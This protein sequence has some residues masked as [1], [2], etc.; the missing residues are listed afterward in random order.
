M[1]DV[2]N[3]PDIAVIGS[4]LMGHGIAQVFAQGGCK[5]RLQDIDEK[6]FQPA[7]SR[8]RANLITLSEHG[9]ENPERV[10]DIIMKISTTTDLAEAVADADF[11]IES[12][13]ENLE[14]K[15]ELFRRIELSAPVDAILATNTSMLKL[16]DIGIH[17]KKKERLI[18]THWFNPPYLMPVVEVVKS[19]YT[20]QDTLD[21]TVDLLQRMGKVPIKVLKELP[22]HLLNRIQFAMFRETISLLE[23]GVAT[24]EEID[25]GIPGSIGLRFATIGPLK[26]IDF[27][28]IDLF[29]N[30]MKD[31]YRSLD[32]S[33]VPQ[34][35]IQ[36]K[37]KAG[38]FGVK[39]GKGFFEYRSGELL[40]S[41]ERERDEKTITLLKMLYPKR[42][43]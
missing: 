22:G 11:V 30:G 18:V 15:S 32:N 1:A 41:E 31:I 17:V 8:I 37:A 6:A 4:G 20:S 5:V 19:S 25:K 13:T 24:A 7:K 29:W 23:Q 10:E 39:S 28:G 12:A 34:R 33:P 42:G 2:V 43:E 36:D 16:S 26:A 3:S 38:E 40:S 9:L 35:I 27:A 14:L 21:Q